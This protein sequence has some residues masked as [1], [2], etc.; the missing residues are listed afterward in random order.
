MGFE[1]KVIDVINNEVFN[2]QTLK[3]KKTKAVKNKDYID[4]ID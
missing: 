3:C 2:E 4:F 1:I